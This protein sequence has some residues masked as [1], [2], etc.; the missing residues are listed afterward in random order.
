MLL[1]KTVALLCS[2]TAAMAANAVISG[3]MFMGEDTT[4]Y[5]ADP[6]EIFRDPN[7]HAGA[8][9]SI[10][11][12]SAKSADFSPATQEPKSLIQSLD[13]FVQ[14]ASSFPGFLSTAALDTSLTLNGSFTQFEK[15]IRDQLKDPHT[16]RAFRD[17]IPGYIQDQSLTDWVLSLVVLTKPEDSD[18][19]NIRF[20]R[21]PLTIE[22]DK[23]NTAYIPKQKA[24]LI[25]ADYNVLTNFFISNADKLAGIMKIVHVRDFTDF[26]D[27]PKVLSQDEETQRGTFSCSKNRQTFKNQQTIMSWFL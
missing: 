22:S 17:L 19:V 9:A 15:V 14:K 12:Y 7:N 21:V 13:A 27:S 1:I 6:A 10:L 25:V 24:R 5:S 3:A 8:A 20:A 4:D 18:T 16:A 2:A 26:F 11:V 23:T